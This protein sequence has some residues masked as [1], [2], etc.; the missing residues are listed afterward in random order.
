MTAG[1]ERPLD[2]VLCVI[3]TW[4]G[5]F[6]Q[7]KVLD[8][9]LSADMSTVV[10]SSSEQGTYPEWHELGDAY[11]TEQM[12]AVGRLFLDSGKAWLF[13][14]MADTV[15]EG[16]RYAEFVRTGIDFNE[17]ER[18]VGFYIPKQDYSP[19]QFE[20]H[21]SEREYAPGVHEIPVASPDILQTLMPRQL[22]FECPEFDFPSNPLGWGIDHVLVKTSRAAGLAMVQDRNFQCVHPKSHGYARPEAKAGL[23]AYV[24][25]YDLGDLPIFHYEGEH[26]VLESGHAEVGRRLWEEGRP[27]RAMR[28]LREG[29]D[30]GC[31]NCVRLIHKL[32]PGPGRRRIKRVRSGIRHGLKRLVGLPPR[33]RQGS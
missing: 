21:E 15:M 10:V 19:W 20:P 33:T 1:D 26:V 14:V 9:K 8:D 3:I 25:R 5:W 16:D 23:K 27:Q 18:P 2:D 29:A 22:W 7:A 24:E 6:D 28:T 30:K 17:R 13:V 4:P 31:R 12:I 32:A 11:F